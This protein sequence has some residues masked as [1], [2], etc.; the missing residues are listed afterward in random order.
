MIIT[1]VRVSFVGN[2]LRVKFRRKLLSGISGLIKANTIAEFVSF[3]QLF[4]RNEGQSLEWQISNEE[5]YA[6]RELRVE[7]ESS[8]YDSEVFVAVGTNFRDNLS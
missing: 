4:T 2:M 5:P 1:I 7:T 3:R 8:V 6:E